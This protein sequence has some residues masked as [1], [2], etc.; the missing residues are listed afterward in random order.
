MNTLTI[1]GVDDNALDELKKQAKNSNSSVNKFI[2]EMLQKIAVPG[3]SGKIKEWDDLD[4]FFGTWSKD[5]YNRVVKS[6]G[7]CRTIDA[8]LWK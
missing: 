3:K 8:E 5:E 4:G 6:S 1:R 2:V 7:K